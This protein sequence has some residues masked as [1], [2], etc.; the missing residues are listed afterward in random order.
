MDM[1]ESVPLSL[2]GPLLVRNRTFRDERGHFVE[3][4]RRD[5]YREI[6]IVEDFVQDNQ[7]LSRSPGIVRGLH[8]QKPPFAQA[9]LVRVLRG[10]ILDVVVDL[11]RGSPTYGRYEATEL[12]ADTHDQLYVPV[13]FAHGFCTLEADT[14]VT[15]KVSAYYAPDHD[16]GIHWADPD[17]GIAWPVSP[18]TAIMSPK[19]QA[20]PCLRDLE[21][22]FS[23]ACP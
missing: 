13:G 19:D 2:Q 23:Y 22:P 11:R 9:K 5:L 20:L 8:F 4:Y 15:Y 17:I 18:S 12:A 6:G 21:S 14:V 16:A 10:R 1:P 3:V 7:S